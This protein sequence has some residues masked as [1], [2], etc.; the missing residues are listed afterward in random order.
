MIGYTKTMKQ[1]YYYFFLFLTNAID[2]VVLFFY[3][4]TKEITQFLLECPVPY[5]LDLFTNSTE[6]KEPDLDP[7]VAPLYEVKYLEKFRNAT[8]EMIWT[9]EETIV[10]QEKRKELLLAYK[11]RQSILE[12]KIKEQEALLEVRRRQAMIHFDDPD[13]ELLVKESEKELEDLKNHPPVEETIEA[14]AF[15]Y[16]LQ[17]RLD[18]LKTN[19]LIEKTPLGNVIMYY[20]N[21]KESFCFFSDFII[22]YRYLEV[23]GRK[24]VLTFQCKNL[25]VDMEMEMKEAEKKWQDHKKWEEEQ[26]RKP[27]TKKDVFVKFKQ[28]NKDTCKTQV[29]NNNNNNNNNRRP[30]P[31]RNNPTKEDEIV[32]LKERANRY[33]YEGKCLN[34]SFLQK[35]DKK[36]TD[37]R[38][39]MSFAD[40]KQM[41]NA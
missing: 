34:Y 18:R 28:Y 27:P 31:P 7:V 20:D 21:K 16:V 41:Q 36:I 8:D 24:Y 2:W 11:N 26:K 29:S 25:Y 32:F 5:T 6:K 17:Q 35:P 1:D 38:L 3:K 30:P 13:L 39:A 33:T 23:V 9:P 14:E 40:F 15:Q 37:K 22:P 19:V 10:E 4:A 12:E